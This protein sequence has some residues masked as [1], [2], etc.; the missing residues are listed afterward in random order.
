MSREINEMVHIGINANLR[1]L[2]TVDDESLKDAVK[3]IELNSNFENL[4]DE[5]G[6]EDFVSAIDEVAS[7]VLYGEDKSDPK[8]FY[9]KGMNSFKFRR[10]LSKVVPWAAGFGTGAF[11][12]GYLGFFESKESFL[13]LCLIV[14]AT[15]SLL[16]LLRMKGNLPVAEN[17]VAYPEGLKNK[18]GS[19]TLEVTGSGLVQLFFE[20]TTD[21]DGMNKAKYVLGIEENPVDEDIYLTH[22]VSLNTLTGIYLWDS[23][24]DIRISKNLLPPLRRILLHS[25]FASSFL[26]TGIGVGLIS[27]PAGIANWFF[28]G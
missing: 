2:A 24:R 5:I 16:G 20:D 11:L 8:S 27:I 12:Y 28:A 25:S 22:F 3:I 15:L 18:S 19:Y 17:F 10:L 6:I 7:L 21:E 9:E 23:E 4:E 1:Y 13:A 14:P 26:G